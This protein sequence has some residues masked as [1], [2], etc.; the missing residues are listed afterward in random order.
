MNNVTVTVKQKLTIPNGVKVIT[1]DG[2]FLTL[3]KKKSGGIYLLFT[4]ESHR[5]EGIDLLDENNWTEYTRAE[6]LS[7]LK[8]K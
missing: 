2:N 1:N 8:I 4:G 5:V 3:A 7:I 6:L